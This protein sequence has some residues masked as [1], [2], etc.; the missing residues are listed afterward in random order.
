[1]VAERRRAQEQLRELND[2]LERRVTARTAELGKS[3]MRL[4]EAD[5]RKDEFLAMLGHELRN[6]LAAIRH[7]VRIDD[8]SLDDPDARQ[9][10]REVID[11]QS[12]QLTRMVDDL[13]DVER[14]N[15]G[16]I[17]LRI[18]ALELDAV[19][20]RAVEAVRPFIEEKKHILAV[21]AESELSVRGDAARLQQVFVNLL[22]N[23]AKYTDEGGRIQ[24]AVRRH[25]AEAVIAISDNG[26]GLTTEVLPR[27]FDLFTQAHTSLDRAQGGLGIGLTVVK[28]LIEMHGG[29]IAVQSEGNAR[30]S[31]FTVRLPLATDSGIAK[32]PTAGR[33]EA[34]AEP[35]AVPPETAP[36]STIRILVVDDHRDTGETLMRLLVRRGYEVRIAHD[37]LEGLAM[38]REF[39]PEVLLLD[40]GLPGL[41]GYELCRALR[42]ESEFAAARI[43]ATSG[44]AQ[45]SDVERSREAG[46]DV[47]FAKPVDLA[48]LIA[49]FRATGGLCV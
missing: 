25:H 21:E 13:L 10:A 14:I 48:A 20:A 28:S 22:S 32:T 3:E 7:A 8:E 11:R 29:S 23:A 34:T 38:A 17:V 27:V 46:F 35:R 36:A 12:A 15:R 40:L 26:V 5:K 37:G 19:L 24:V 49:A 42:A 2:E 43:I 4:R 9:L 44:Y 6:P 31:T 47:H 30:G 39:R 1:E 41:D 33:P 16:R 18:E 45:S